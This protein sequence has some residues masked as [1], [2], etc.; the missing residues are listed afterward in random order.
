MSE[1]LIVLACGL[2][3]VNPFYINF[4]NFSHK[5][6]KSFPSPIPLDRTRRI[7]YNEHSELIRA[8]K[9]L[10]VNSSAVNTLQFSDV[11]QTIQVEFI[12]GRQYSYEVPDYDEVKE[13]LINES[14]L[15]E[16]GKGSVGK[17][18]NN[19]I[20]SEKLKNYSFL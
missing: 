5:F 17:L 20:K 3:F 19:L 9:V 14:Y 10:T 11:D 18:L 15:A 12:N 2:P 16:E 6:S 4:P 13:E 1:G 8:M 7:T